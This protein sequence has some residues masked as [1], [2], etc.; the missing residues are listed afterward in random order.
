MTDKEKLL[1]LIKYCPDDLES[2]LFAYIQRYHDDFSAIR[3]RSLISKLD[4]DVLMIKI[5]DLEN[6][7]RVSS[8]RA[9]WL[10]DYLNGRMYT[11]EEDV[12]KNVGLQIEHANKIKKMCEDIPTGLRW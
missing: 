9:T 8:E 7:V 10:N 11:T 3:V 1:D 5:L 4:R 6:A 12:K 2:I